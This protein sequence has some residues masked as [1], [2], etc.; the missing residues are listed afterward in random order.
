MHSTGFQSSLCCK[1]NGL[2]A[3][4]GGQKGARDA[5]P[6]KRLEPPVSTGVPSVV[7]WRHSGAQTTYQKILWL[8]V[9]VIPQKRFEHGTPVGSHRVLTE[10]PGTLCTS[11]SDQQSAATG[12]DTERASADRSLVLGHSHSRCC[13]WP[14]GGNRRWTARPTVHHP[15]EGRRCATRS[16]H[17]W[18]QPN[19]Q[20]L[21]ATYNPQW[22]LAWVSR[23]CQV[24]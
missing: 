18:W 7:A 17:G 13:R 22:Y 3:S 20:R 14:L 10:V 19:C 24:V 15:T 8:T 5:A 23:L 12:R 21:Q 6:R 4:D 16:I 9:R 2:T 1:A 11:A